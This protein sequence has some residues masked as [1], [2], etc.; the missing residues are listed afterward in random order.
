MSKV[1]QINVK[2]L[3]WFC[4]YVKVELFFISNFGVNVG[5]N[6]GTNFGTNIGADFGAKIG[7]NFGA[8]IG[9]GGGCKDT[10]F[11][12]NTSAKIGPKLQPKLRPKLGPI[13]KH[14]T[15]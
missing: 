4:S 2:I 14:K 9:G 5:A 3:Q 6:F 10:S 12:P 8:K 7:S 15:S 1:D 13:T 11:T